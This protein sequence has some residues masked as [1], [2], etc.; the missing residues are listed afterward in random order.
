MVV[1]K[2]LIR[3]YGSKVGLP[4]AL[5]LKL[6]TRHGKVVSFFSKTYK[7][8]HN[9]AS[10]QTFESYRSPVPKEFT[11]VRATKVNYYFTTE[12]ID[13]ITNRIKVIQDEVFVI[14]A[15]HVAPLLGSIRDQMEL[16]YRAAEIVT[17]LDV[18]Q[19]NWLV[20]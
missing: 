3:G 7:V 4:V 11:K 13:Q 8:S 6:I 5:N 12:K 1:R 16:F 19:R 2:G 15:D 10:N 18:L 9:Q 20:K 17:E 14:T